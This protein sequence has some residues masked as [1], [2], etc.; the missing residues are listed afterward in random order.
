[1]VR[2]ACVYLSDGSPRIYESDRSFD[3]FVSTY[4]FDLLSPDFM[5][6]RL[7]EGR[8]LLVPEGKLCLRSMT[9]AA[10][11]CRVRFAGLATVVSDQSDI[12]GANRRCRPGSFMSDDRHRP[13]LV[14]V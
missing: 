12:G 8:R 6:Q 10:N 1:M 9:F 4:L 14:A 2:R 7:S 11:H 3:R 5:D 13:V